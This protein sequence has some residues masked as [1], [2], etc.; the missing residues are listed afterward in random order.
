MPSDPN[1]DTMNVG[2]R[3]TKSQPDNTEKKS[4]AINSI[5]TENEMV[6][7]NQEEKK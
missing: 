3:H 7:G 1:R 5:E 2:E 6:T 4:R